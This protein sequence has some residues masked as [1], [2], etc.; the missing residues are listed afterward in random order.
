MLRRIEA[1]R[2][3]F[4]LSYRRDSWESHLEWVW[5]DD[6]N[7]VSDL[8]DEESSRGYSVLNLLL[9]KTFSGSVRAEVGV[10]NLLEKHYADHLGGVNRVTG[11]DLAVGERIPGAGRFTYA[12]VSWEF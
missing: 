7:R 12:S 1:L 11:G 9:A 6:Q 5:A 2:G 8:Q 4:D 10:E 3:M